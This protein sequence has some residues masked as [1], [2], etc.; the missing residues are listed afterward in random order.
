M[1]VQERKRG[2][3]EIDLTLFFVMLFMSTNKMKAHIDEKSTCVTEI[4]LNTH[5]SLK[6]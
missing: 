1:Q 6:D 4:S 3:G 5:S 2:S